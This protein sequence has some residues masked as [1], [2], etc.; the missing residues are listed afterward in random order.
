MQPPLATLR[1]QRW[2]VVSWDDHVGGCSA[3][4]VEEACNSQRL[5]SVGLVMKQLKLCWRSVQNSQTRSHRRIDGHWNLMQQIKNTSGFF[6][7]EFKTVQRQHQHRTEQ[8]HL[9]R[10]CLQGGVVAKQPS[11]WCGSSKWLEVERMEERGSSWPRLMSLHLK[12]WILLKM[13]EDWRCP[14][15]QADTLRHAINQNDPSSMLQKDW[16]HAC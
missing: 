13:V 16:L 5:P 4:R 14:E 6:P 11:I 2:A 7:S 1:S 3:T 10:S 12:G 15:S 8:S 9:A